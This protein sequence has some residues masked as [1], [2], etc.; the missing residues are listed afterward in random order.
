M[1]NL[2]Q[3]AGNVRRAI[4]DEGPA[5]YFHRRTINQLSTD[6]PTLYD[7]IEE[8]IDAYEAGDESDWP[9]KDQWNLLLQH[10]WTGRSYDVY[11]VYVDTERRETI[12][13]VGNNEHRIVSE[14]EELP[15]WTKITEEAYES[16]SIF[17]AFKNV[18]VKET[19]WRKND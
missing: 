16:G 17:D 4:V 9:P 5:P 14:G 18:Y 3:A 19:V 15:Q 6:W 12:A 11:L 10:D 8:L 1:T 13:Y 7:A 2:R